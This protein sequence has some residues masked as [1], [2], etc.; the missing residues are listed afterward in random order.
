MKT[1]SDDSPGLRLL[2]RVLA[3]TDAA[4]WPIRRAEWEHIL[5]RRPFKRAGMPSGATVASS[6]QALA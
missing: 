3:A 5:G 1:L 6:C 4:F 2:V